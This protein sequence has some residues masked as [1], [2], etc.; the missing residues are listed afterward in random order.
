MPTRIP[1][2]IVTLRDGEPNVLFGKSL[3]GD[4]LYADSGKTMLEI[5]DERGGAR[6]QTFVI[7]DG[8]HIAK[9]EAL[10][11]RMERAGVKMEI[12]EDGED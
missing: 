1:V 11:D 4:T 6:V 9:W 12:E 10:L 5:I 3:H 7:E 8:P 2:A